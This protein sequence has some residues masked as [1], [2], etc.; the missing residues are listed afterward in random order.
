LACEHGIIVKDE[1]SY[2]IEGRN[3]DS[4]EAAK[5]FLAQNDAICDKL[6][7][8]MRRQLTFCN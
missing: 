1:G 2:L 7:K 5:L 3:F 4:R 6:V 8:D